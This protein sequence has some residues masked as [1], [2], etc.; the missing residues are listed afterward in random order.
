V[1]SVKQGEHQYGLTMA[2]IEQVAQQGL[3]CVTHMQLQVS[4]WTGQ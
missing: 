2:A 3:A 1:E 4:T